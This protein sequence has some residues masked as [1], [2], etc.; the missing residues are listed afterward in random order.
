MLP[1]ILQQLNNP[2]VTNLMSNPQALSAIMQIRQGMET[3]RQTAPNLMNTFGTGTGGLL[4]STTSTT[5]TSQTNTTTTATNQASGTTT[6]T[7][8]AAA[9]PPANDTFTEVS[10]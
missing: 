7:S 3:L 10:Y 6:T 5:P 1:T 9:G 8:A 4:T 2:E